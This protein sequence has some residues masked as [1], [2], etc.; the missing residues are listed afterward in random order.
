MTIP[1]LRLLVAATDATMATGWATASEIK[2][3]WEEGLD[4]HVAAGF[5]ERRADGAYGLTDKAVEAI[6]DL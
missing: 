5:L 1:D 3:T 6:H 2:V 4:A